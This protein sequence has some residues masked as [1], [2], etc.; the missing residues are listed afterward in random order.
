MLSRSVFACVCACVC[1]CVCVYTHASGKA[2]KEAEAMKRRNW[3]PLVPSGHLA[4][5]ESYDLVVIM[6]GTRHTIRVGH[7]SHRQLGGR[8]KMGAEGLLPQRREVKSFL[9]FPKG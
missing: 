5:E 8:G 2:K 6:V 9:T 7:T 4:G 1:V 3:E